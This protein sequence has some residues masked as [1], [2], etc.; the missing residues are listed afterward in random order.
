MA[1]RLNGVKIEKSFIKI[2][3][4]RKNKLIIIINYHLK[5]L[6][7]VI[8]YIYSHIIHIKES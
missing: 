5:G 4:Y 1:T 8:I 2:T 3:N 6:L 7:K